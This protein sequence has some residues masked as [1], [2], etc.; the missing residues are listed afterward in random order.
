L[1]GDLILILVLTLVLTVD[2]TLILDQSQ[3]KTLDLG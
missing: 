2:L 3:V 1:P